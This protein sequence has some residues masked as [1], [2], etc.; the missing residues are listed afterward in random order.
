MGAGMT[1][2]TAGMMAVVTATATLD[3]RCVCSYRAPCPAALILLS[4]LTSVVLHVKVRLHC[5][6]TTSAPVTVST[7]KPKAV[8][9]TTGQSGSLITTVTTPLVFADTDQPHLGENYP[10]HTEMTLVYQSAAWILAGLLLAIIIFVIVA[11]LINK[12][13]KW[14]QMSCYSAP[15]K[16]VI[17]KKHVNKNSVIYMDPSKE[18]NFQNMKS[19]CGIIN[20]S[21]E[22]SSPPCT[23][24]MTIPRA[25]LSMGSDWTPC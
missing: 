3:G 25:K 4:S 19:N 5:E 8:V 6:S 22:M 20:F 24:K 15:K 13:K 21:P 12:K 11:L 18:N 7:S 9:T 16:T 2:V 1:R 17:L 23:E 14:V 10:S